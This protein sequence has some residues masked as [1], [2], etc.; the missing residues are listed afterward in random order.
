MTITLSGQAGNVFNITKTN[1][2][3]NVGTATIGYTTE[4]L[5]SSVTY[6]NSS[7]VAALTGNIGTAGT[8]IVLSALVNVT[9]SSDVLAVADATAPLT[10]TTLKA[11]QVVNKS[12]T[13][14]VT[15]VNAASNSF[16]PASTLITIPP[17]TATYVSSVQFTYPNS[18]ITASS[19]DQIKFV[20]TA[21][22]TNIE[23]YLLG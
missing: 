22:G 17:S 5:A 23:V 11:F 20:S 1:T 14:T 10:F 12:T 7:T 21:N 13:A 16:L 18:A 2:A 19:N 8:T 3:T 4:A 9:S 15:V 6:T